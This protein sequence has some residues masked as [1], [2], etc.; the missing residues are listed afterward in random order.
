M[1]ETIKYVDLD[2]LSHFKAKCDNE[3]VAKQTG[4]GL[5]TN[6]F[7]NEYKQKLENLEN[8]D[9]SEI[10][11]ELNNKANITDIPDI[12]N[13]QTKIDSEHKLSSDLVDD[14]NNT[15][16]FVT[17][18]EKATWDNK[19]NFSGSYNDLT[20]KPT[21]PSEVTETTISNWGFTKNSGTYNKPQTGIPK[22][23]LT[24]E[25]QTSL[26]KAD[27]AL[28]S[29]TEQY[30]GTITGIT[31]NGE[32]IGTSGVVDL[33]TVITEHQDISSKEN[34]ANKVTLLN[35]SST[36]EQYPSAKSVYNLVNCKIYGIKRSLTTT[37][38][39]W[40]RTDDSIGLEANATKD[41][42]VTYND[43]DNIYPWSD[44]YTYNYDRTTGLE[45][46]RIGDANFKFDGTNGEV[47]TKIPEFY[48]RRYRDD[49]Y[50]YIQIS[51]YPIDGFIKSEEFSVGRY[52]ST[53]I[54][55]TIHSYSNT[56]PE[57]NRTITSF[58]NL[59]R[60]VGNNF[61][62][63]DWRY[64]LIHILYLVE[65]ADYNSQNKLG[66]GATGFRSNANDKALV[67]ESNVNRII[68]STTVANNFEAGQQISIGTNSISNFGVARCRTIITKESYDENGVTGTAVYFDGEPV[69]IEL[70]NVIWTSAQ[71]NGV[72]DNLG[73]KSG[74]YKAIKNS[75]IYRGVENPFGNVSQIIDGINIKSNIAYICYNPEDYEVDK[76][77]GNYR[78]ISYTNSDIS[79]D[80]VKK[81]G[82]DT[83]N[84][85]ICF[86]T[87]V[88]GSDSTNICDS[89]A[90]LSASATYSVIAIIGGYVNNGTNAGMW[91]WDLRYGSNYNASFI[92][93]RLLRY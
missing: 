25:V 77:D 84:P 6:D 42:S 62:Q 23:D 86:P 57:V 17:A 12:S 55:G 16:K 88:G 80:W 89:Y 3:Y 11:Q 9:D 59:S 65:Y 29:Y 81:L 53:V 8:Y 67:T 68:V 75:C 4:K 15:N 58:R 1:S 19:S 93:S 73:M 74:C 22:T 45:T 90:C 7:T 33:G 34:N 60:E 44:I 54:N 32:S 70:G 46:A 27:T 91:F 30:T 78:N 56:E 2:G 5:S 69:N 39:E 35:S 63:L 82:Y 66:N 20:N 64:F 37:S 41:G 85:L 10:L 50:E 83:N 61:G 79:A 28:Q 49:D 26:G 43:F 24:N 72:C 21:I 87:K 14:T 51:K 48:Y 47:L 40:H 36:D 52:D 76:I 31:M 71:K 38:S 13:Y 18:S 92:G